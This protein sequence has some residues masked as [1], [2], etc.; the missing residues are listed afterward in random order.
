MSVRAN[1]FLILPFLTYLSGALPSFSN[2]FFMDS[3]PLLDSESTS[4]LL[5]ARHQNQVNDTHRLSL[6]Q[7]S[8]TQVNRCNALS[9]MAQS[10]VWVRHLRD[11]FGET[12]GGKLLRWVWRSNGAEV[13]ILTLPSFLA[14]EARFQ[15]AF[16]APRSRIVELFGRKLCKSA[17]IR[18]PGQCRLYTFDLDSSLQARNWDRLCLWSDCCGGLSAVNGQAHGGLSDAMW[19]H[20]GRQSG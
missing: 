8:W 13:P 20:F 7:R 9:L 17:P 4:P 5:L 16:H 11:L 12:Q 10:I 1:L 3:S 2:L 15:T 6:G 18:H 19:R 14:R